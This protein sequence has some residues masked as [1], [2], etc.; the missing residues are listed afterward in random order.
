M[1]VYARF[2]PAQSALRGGGIGA[3]APLL[4]NAECTNF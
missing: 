2:I 1:K 4:L 3:T